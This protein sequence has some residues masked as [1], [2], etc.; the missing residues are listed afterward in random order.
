NGVDLATPNVDE[1]R[2]TARSAGTGEPTIVE[3]AAL[4][5]DVHRRWRCPVAVTAG[6][7]GALLADAGA[8]QLV[9]T[10]AV[11]G[12]PC[13]AG[14]HLAAPSAGARARGAARAEALGPGVERATAPV[15]GHGLRPR[16]APASAE[17]AVV[18]AAVRRRGG[19]LVAAGGCFDILHPGHVSLLERA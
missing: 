1:A 17:A 11:G 15:G 18:A 9:T 19:T 3:L 2:A 7:V 14:D 10:T 12:D 8:V 6:P 13:G 4:A 16:A 5:D